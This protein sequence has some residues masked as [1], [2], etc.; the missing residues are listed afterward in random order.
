VVGEPFHREEIL[1]RL[2]KLTERVD[3]LEKEPK[4]R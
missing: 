4:K 2:R 1:E 3:A